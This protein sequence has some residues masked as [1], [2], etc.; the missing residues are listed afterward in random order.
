MA[1]P[2]GKWRVGLQPLVA[3]CSACAD[4]AGQEFRSVAILCPSLQHI[5]IAAHKLPASVLVRFGHYDLQGR[6]HQVAA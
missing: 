1:H 2:A 3:Y 4:M 5:G 6:T